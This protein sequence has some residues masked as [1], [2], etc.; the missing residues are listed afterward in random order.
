MVGAALTLRERAMLGDAGA[1]LAGA[2]AGVAL[3]AAL[4]TDARLIALVVVALLTIY[5][6]FR[7][8]SATIERIAPLRALDRIG[9]LELSRRSELLRQL[10]VVDALLEAGETV[11]GNRRPGGRVGR[12][13]VE[14]GA[15]AGV[16]VEAAHPHADDSSRPRGCG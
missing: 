6:E 9:R 3:F 16:V 1:N 2:V 14:G 10:G 11:V 15:D 7:S 4:G 13:L 12:E 5:G 8:I